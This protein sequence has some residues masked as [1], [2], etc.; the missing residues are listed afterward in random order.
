M[1]PL[2][3]VLRPYLR[4]TPGRTSRRRTPSASGI[5]QILSRHEATTWKSAAASSRN[6]H[7]ASGCGLG[8]NTPPTTDIG[9]NDDSRESLRG[10]AGCAWCGRAQLP[11]SSARAL[12]HRLQSINMDCFGST[13]KSRFVGTMSVCHPQTD[14]RGQEVLRLESANRRHCGGLAGFPRECPCAVPYPQHLRRDPSASGCFLYRVGSSS[15]GATMT[16]SLPL[17]SM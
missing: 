7:A 15:S 11:T 6:S 17:R 10:T 14:A 2:P 8:P 9:N 4:P 5:H 3:Y 16:S 1:L 13:Q 12:L